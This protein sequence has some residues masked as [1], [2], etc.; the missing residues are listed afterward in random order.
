MGGVGGAAR[1]RG[2]WGLRHV[3]ANGARFRIAEMGSGPL[4]LFLHGFPEFWWAWRHQL[5]AV[6]AAGFHAVAMDLRGYGGSDKPPRGYDPLTLA[7]DVT[8]VVRT[9]GSHDA[10]LV[11]HGWGGYIAWTAASADP[12]CVRALATVC[13]PHPARMLRAR[14]LLRRRAVAHLLATQVP[15]LP[16]R[17]LVRGSYLARHLAA[18]SSPGSSFPTPEAVDVYREALAQWPAPH[19]ALEY[20]RWLLRSRFR[21]DGRAFA[22]VVRRRIDAPVLQVHGGAADAVV[23]AAAVRTSA[24]YVEASH[25]VVMVPDAGHYPHEEQPTAVTTA[26]LSWLDRGSAGAVAR[27]HR[28]G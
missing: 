19:C 21:A 7:A 3:S 18:W 25:D 5:P 11:G 9:L 2:P 17:R 4:V 20:H 13:A 10:V 27:R 16:E 26:L 6:A 23:S 15:W 1:L 8:G 14:E 28:L 24:Q 12:G 22:A